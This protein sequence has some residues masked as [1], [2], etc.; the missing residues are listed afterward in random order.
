VGQT[1]FLTLV[2]KPESWKL[3]GPFRKGSVSVLA[4]RQN[5]VYPV[6]NKAVQFSSLGLRFSNWWER[7]FTRELEVTVSTGAGEPVVVGTI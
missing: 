3:N 5:E 4:S 6:S 2:R 1:H 7:L